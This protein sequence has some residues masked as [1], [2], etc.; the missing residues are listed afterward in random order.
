MKSNLK[1]NRTNTS[2]NSF[3]T[4]ITNKTNTSKLPVN[5]SILPTEITLFVVIKNTRLKIF[6]GSGTQNLLWLFNYAIKQYSND[7]GFQC[8]LIYGY[9][10]EEGCLIDTEFNVK[11]I[12]KTFA[13]NTE[14]KLLLKPEYDVAFE[15]QKKNK[16]GKKTNRGLSNTKTRR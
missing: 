16:K 4:N 7:L 14:V 11:S 2:I 6:C 10:D 13:N 1:S 15:E 5:K 12:R 8:G 3:K 9:F